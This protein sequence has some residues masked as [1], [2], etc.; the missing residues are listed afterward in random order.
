MKLTIYTDGGSRGNPG[1]AASAYWV[2]NNA[3]IV[4][5]KCGKCIGIET[6]NVAEYRAVLFAWEWIDQERDRLINLGE[7]SFRLDS[8]LVVK[9]ISGVYRIKDDNLKKLREEIAS[10]QARFEVA[11]PTVRITYTYV[12][13]EQ[14]KEADR[15]VNEALDAKTF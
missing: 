7:V 4:L 14:N 8:E 15:L 9:Q 5:E 3:G 13:R 1:L 2:I 12:P 11:N 6:N 10:R